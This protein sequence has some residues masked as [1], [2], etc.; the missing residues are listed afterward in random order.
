VTASTVKKPPSAPL[1]RHV[2]PVPFEGEDGLFR[3]SWHALCKSTDV[4]LGSVIGRDFL[5]GRVVIYRGM[6]GLIRVMSA[7]CPHLGADLSLGHV[8]G[9]NLQCA[10]HH[11]E[12]DTNGRCERTGIGD[13]APPGACL[14]RFPCRE[15]FGVVWAFNGDTPLFD[16]ADLS[17]PIEQTVVNVADPMSLH[18]DPWVVCCNTPDWVHFA[19]VH[20][21]DVAKEGLH[22]T[23][24]FTDYGVERAF[25]TRLEH[26]KGP[27]IEFNVKVSGT[28][29]VLVEG[30]LE[31][32]W[33]AVAGCMG[34]PRPGLTNFFIINFADAAAEPST[35]AAQQA[36]LTSLEISKRMGGED[37]PIW[38]TMHFKAG[39]LTRSDQ[40]LATYLERLRQ[41]PRSHPSADFIN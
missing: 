12:Y 6:D 33:F 8:K 7:Y 32:K 31:G 35:E 10:F 19:M 29:L 18:T 23:I 11:W 15:K 20:R 41:Y 37:A 39:Q 34:I 22:K 5:D 38:D 26:G 21:F 2:N 36:L 13:P 9:N 30:V 17:I 3:Q 27:E 4:P 1:K 28:S 40:A 14:F 25:K 16:L 24:R